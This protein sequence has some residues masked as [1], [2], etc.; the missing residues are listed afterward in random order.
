MNFNFADMLEAVVDVVPDR[1]ALI[2]EDTR[3]NFADLEARSN[4]M[5]HHF[6]SAGIKYGEHV[7][8]YAYNGVEWV[9]SMAALY[10]MRAVPVNINFR[11]VENELRYLFD[12]ADL[13][14]LVVQREFV[15]SG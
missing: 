8:I 12:N 6:Q 4:Q 13:R 14:A 2:F 9:E 15:P 11:Y 1:T 10:K 7:G 5:A 3:L